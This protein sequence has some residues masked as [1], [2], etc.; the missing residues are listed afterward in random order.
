MGAIPSH[1]GACH[2]IKSLLYLLTRSHALPNSLSLSLFLSL[3]PA[4]FLSLSP[5]TTI[6]RTALLTGSSHLFV[7]VWHRE[8]VCRPLFL[9]LDEMRIACRMWKRSGTNGWNGPKANHPGRNHIGLAAGAASVVASACSCRSP[10]VFVLGLGP[11][12]R[13]PGLPGEW[14]PRLSPRVTRAVYCLCATCLCVC[15]ACWHWLAVVWLA[16]CVLCGM[17]VCLPR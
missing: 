15:A 8:E 3:L 11:G 6:I 10:W 2:D 9:D 17:V 4:H 12:P 14:A 7:L 13:L 16:G 5:L 1:K